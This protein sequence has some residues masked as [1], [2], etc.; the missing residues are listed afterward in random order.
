MI[1]MTYH[2]VCPK[3][4]QTFSYEELVDMRRFV[5]AMMHQIGCHRT[6][7]IRIG[8][9][10]AGSMWMDKGIVR[11]QTKGVRAKRIVNK[12]GTIRRH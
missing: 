2:V 11:W 6:I 1:G 5:Y 10:K 4:K 12:D 8:K 3:S 9:R 7:V